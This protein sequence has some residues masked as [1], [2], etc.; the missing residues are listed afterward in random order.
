MMD[1]IWCRQHKKFDVACI[2][3]VDKIKFFQ[4]E[5]LKTAYPRGTPPN[6]FLG[7]DVLKFMDKND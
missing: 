4:E 1:E 7:K 6:L 5:R 3:L 2:P